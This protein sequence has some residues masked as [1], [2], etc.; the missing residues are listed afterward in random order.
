[1]TFMAIEGENMYISY[2]MMPASKIELKKHLLS[3][4]RSNGRKVE[5]QRAGIEIVKW[6]LKTQ[7]HSESRIFKITESST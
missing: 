4:R 6:S 1:M 7:F 3:D 2:Q 5:Q